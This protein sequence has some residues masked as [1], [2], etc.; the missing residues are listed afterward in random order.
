MESKQL[1]EGVE[2]AV[3]YNEQGQAIGVLHRSKE[4][5]DVTEKEIIADTVADVT[6]DITIFKPG[7]K[8]PC[9]HKSASGK[10]WC[11]C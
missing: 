3:F 8:E 7:S 9:C 2:Y 11:W 5:Y 10:T 4:V 6:A 1:P